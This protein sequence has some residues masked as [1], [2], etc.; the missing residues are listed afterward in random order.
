MQRVC[1]HST[2]HLLQ[3]LTFFDVE[4]LPACGLTG[5]CGCI[6]LRSVK[7][8]PTAVSPVQ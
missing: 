6:V 1:S 2:S 3:V 8:C 7:S 4:L 5:Q